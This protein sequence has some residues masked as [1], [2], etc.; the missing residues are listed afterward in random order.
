MIFNFRE[1]GFIALQ[2][3]RKMNKITLPF[4]FLKGSI[5]Q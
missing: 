3:L 5:K 1:K 4:P 2:L